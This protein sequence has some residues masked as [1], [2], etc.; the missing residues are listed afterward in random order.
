MRILIPFKGFEDYQLMQTVNQIKKQL[1]LDREVFEEEYW[2]NK[3]LTNPVPWTVIKTTSGISFF[4]ANDKLFKIYVEDNNEFALDNGIQI[5]M[6]L[7]KAREIDLE[8]SYDD[9]NEDWNSPKGYWL[10][11]SID[12]GNIVSITIFINAVMDDEVFDK[13]EW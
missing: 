5:G 3:E 7:E 11:D 2:D 4:F 13:Y 12:T 10:E 1:T 8:L 6:P 9:W